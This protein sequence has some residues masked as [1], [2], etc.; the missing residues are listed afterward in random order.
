VKVSLLAR[1]CFVKLRD[2]DVG[3]VV[4]FP[5]V[6]NVACLLPSLPAREVGE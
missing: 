3:V 1:V 6:R 2:R 5:M 4:S